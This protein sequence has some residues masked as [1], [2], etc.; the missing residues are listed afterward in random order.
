MVGEIIADDG[1]WDDYGDSGYY[2]GGGGAPGSR[3]KPPMR[4]GFDG[5]ND[6]EYGPRHVVH[7]RGLPYRAIE[8]DI[9]MVLLVLKVYSLFSGE[10]RYLCFC[11]VV[12]SFSARWNLLISELYTTKRTDLLARRLS[13]SVVTKKL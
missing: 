12:A 3:M 4:G 8:D 1:D 5:G 2:G 7:M 11:S 13:N 10:L 9:A 6:S